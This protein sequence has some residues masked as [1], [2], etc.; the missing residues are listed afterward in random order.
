MAIQTSDTM[1]ATC[2]ALDQ[3]LN[4]V[5]VGRLQSTVQAMK[6]APGL[7][8]FTF[9]VSNR[10]LEG[11]RNRSEVGAFRGAGGEHHRGEFVIDSSEPSPMAGGDEAP[12][13][14]EYLLHALVGCLTTTFVYHASMEG[15]R[16]Q[17]IES[18]VEGHVDLRSFLGLR[19]ELPGGFEAVRVHFR[20]S[21][22]CPK[23]KVAS[24]M[25][26]ARR[27]SPVANFVVRAVPTSVV[28]EVLEPAGSNL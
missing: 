18:R 25:D 8:K 14:V 9:R 26:A 21:A 17:A 5:D 3:G 16:I 12:T 7:A 2:Q 19:E 23:D 6:A 13:P 10:W 24:L 15:V 28:C 4:G 11:G 1:D 27:R 20:V 22:D